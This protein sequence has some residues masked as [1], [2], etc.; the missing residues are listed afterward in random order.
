MQDSDFSRYQAKV[1]SIDHHYYLVGEIGEPEEYLDLFAGLREAQQG[2][3]FHIHINTPGGLFC[4]AA[5]IIHHMRHSKA[6]IHTYAEGKVISGG[7]LVFFSGHA[8]HVGE[9]SEFLAHAPHGADYGKVADV[10]GHS[11]H[12]MAYAKDFYD[13]V[14]KPF[15]SDEEV[16]QILNGKELWETASQVEKRLIEAKKFFEEEDV[17]ED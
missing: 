17:A 11:Q 14:Y 2:D 9:L 6:Y 16:E 5:Q 3:V 8:L 1:S 10:L 15:Y 13:S 7:S 4:T 12:K